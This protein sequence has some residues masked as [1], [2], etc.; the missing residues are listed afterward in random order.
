[1]CIVGR[2]GMLLP[3]PFLRSHE[4]PDTADRSDPAAGPPLPEVDSVLQAIDKQHR[5]REL[6]EES[7]TEPRRFQNGTRHPACRKLSFQ[8]KTFLPIETGGGQTLRCDSS[9]LAD[10]R[11]LPARTQ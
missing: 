2:R 5:F 4:V 10:C 6:M 7:Q 1:M 3:S 11:N 9:A 8:V